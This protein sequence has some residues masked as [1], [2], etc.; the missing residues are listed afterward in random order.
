MGQIGTGI[1]K[2][3]TDGEYL[4]A[5]DLDQVFEIIRTAIND[6]YA[7]LVARYSKTDI[8]TMLNNMG[9]GIADT[10][11]V[12]TEI[13][14]GTIS[15]KIVLKVPEFSVYYYNAESST[16]IKAATSAELTAAINTLTESTTTSI[17]AVQTDLTNHKNNISNPHGVTP[18]QIGAIPTSA[19][20]AANGVPS[21]GA[22]T[23]IPLAQ[24]P[25]SIM[26]SSAR[27]QNVF[28]SGLSHDNDDGGSAGVATNGQNNWFVVFTKSVTK[29]KGMRQLRLSCSGGIFSTTST[30]S[31]GSGG[32]SS[33][34][35]YINGV[36]K[37]D[38]SGVMN[39]TIDITD[40]ADGATITVRFDMYD[41]LASSSYAYVQ[42]DTYTN[43]IYDII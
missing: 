13:P 20:G 29:D 23:K 21:L 17:A 11:N 15:G 4:K 10:L 1:L 30:Y 8:D 9:A 18:V 26:K 24:V 12:V 33:K 35:V 27:T 14:T 37:L 41:N 5:G 36:L 22:D 6:N 19:K 16:W 38:M 42:V 3:F 28:V 43:E 7:G 34:R 39:H 25:T 32:G 2:D 40:I 31:G